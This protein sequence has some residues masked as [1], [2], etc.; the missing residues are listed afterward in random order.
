MCLSQIRLRQALAKQGVSTDMLPWKIR[1]QWIAWFGLTGNVFFVFFQGW[2]S[3]VPWDI[4]KFFMNYIVVIIFLILAVG[5]KLHHKT[6]FVR[7]KE[8]DLVSHRRDILA[9]A[10]DAQQGIE[11]HTG[12]KSA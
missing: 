10:V 2:T 1:S 4:E 12:D 6:R 9:V 3:F 7:S 8:A 11:S 5:W